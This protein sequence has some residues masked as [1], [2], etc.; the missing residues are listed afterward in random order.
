MAFGFG[1]K[2]SSGGFGG[3]GGFGAPSS[4]SGFG[5]FGAAS[6][7]GFGGFGAASSSSGFGGFGGFGASSS[8]PGFGGF[9]GFGAASSSGGFGGFGGFGAK[10][11]GGFGGFGGFG[12][13]STGGFGGFGGFGASSSSAMPM[14]DPLIHNPP[15]P[16][17]VASVLQSQLK[18]YHPKSGYCAFQAFLYIL[19]DES[20]MDTAWATVQREKKQEGYE[21]SAEQWAV[22]KTQNPDPTRLLP[23]PI[24]SNVELRDRNRQQLAIRERYDAERRRLLAL[25][26]DM[27]RNFDPNEPGS[28]DVA[29][30]EMIQQMAQLRTRIHGTIAN[31]EMHRPSRLPGTD[32]GAMEDKLVH[33]DEKAMQAQ[34]DIQELHAVLRQQRVAPVRRGDLDSSLP[35]ETARGWM[36]FLAQQ[37]KGLSEIDALV[38]GTQEDVEIVSGVR[39]PPKPPGSALGGAAHRRAGDG[40]FG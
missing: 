32:M 22:G 31:M 1:A 12:A 33:A 21:F 38:T 35:P 14:V 16:G 24:R 4:S 25:L 29:I 8:T 23:Y 11:T 18:Q 17:Q 5:G 2:S 10:S 7:G 40:G 27:K 34:R 37:Q 28:L 9:G 36:Q 15:P 26:Q 3:F 39:E 19:M 13:A 20:K 30:R 6:T